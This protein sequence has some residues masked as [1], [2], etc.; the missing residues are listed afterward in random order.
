MFS[1][2]WK[3]IH[4]I[5][6]S[7]YTPAKVAATAVKNQPLL[8]PRIEDGTFCALLDTGSSTSLEGDEAIRATMAG[9]ASLS[10]EKRC[11]CLA[12]LGGL[13]QPLL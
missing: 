10:H 1:R 11:S 13:R 12:P 9:R 5:S 8:E 7:V 2:R 6:T 4:A 3:T